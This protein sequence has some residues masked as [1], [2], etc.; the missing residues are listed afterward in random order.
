MSKTVGYMGKKKLQDG[1]EFYNLEINLPFCPKME[2]YVAKNDLKNSPD[3]KASAPDYLVSYARNQV[4]AV[5][6][7]T[8]KTG[9]EYLS[10]EIFAPVHPQ[11]KLNFACF[12]DQNA[13]ECYKVSYSEPSQKKPTEEEVPY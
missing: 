6:K 7:K 13:P 5:W 2:F 12:P 3:A 11:G 9:S 10:C 1:K 4:G 8:S